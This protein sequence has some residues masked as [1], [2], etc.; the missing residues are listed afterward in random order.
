MSK[1]KSPREKKSLSL[2]RDRRNT[3]GENSK[4]SR[5]AIPRRKQLSHM[6]D[7]RAVNQILNHLRETAEETDASEVDVLAKTR[8]IERKHKAFKKS[9]DSP[10]GIVVKKKLAKRRDQFHAKGTSSYL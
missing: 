7:R 5:K 2:K 4:A 3:Y 9:P 10:L 8:L 1:V 6:G